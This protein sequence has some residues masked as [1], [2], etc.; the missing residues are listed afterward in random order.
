MPIYEFKNTI[1]NEVFEKH[2]SYND[3][4]LFLSE[5]GNIKSHFS[6]FP[7]LCDPVRLGVTKPN[8]GWKE[9]LQKINERTPGSTLK[10]HSNLTQL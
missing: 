1:T 4:E 9:V 5:N 8:E 10:D 3:K 7:G 2:M 6:K